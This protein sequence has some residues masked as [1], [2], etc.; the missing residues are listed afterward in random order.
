MNRPFCRLALFAT[1]CAGWAGKA[2]AQGTQPADQ[3]T[4]P[5]PPAQPGPAPGPQ[6]APYPYPYPYPY[7]APGPQ[8]GGYPQPQG[9]QLAPYPPTAYPLSGPTPYP[10]QYPVMPAAELA[11]A[12]APE[13]APMEIP[14]PEAGSRFAFGAVLGFT[15]ISEENSSLTVSN[16]LLQGRVVLWNHFLADVDWGFILARDSDAGFSARTGNP[17]I[18]AWYRRAFGG[19]QLQGG[20]GI[21]IP[22]ATTTLG[23]DGRLQRAL[24]NHSAALWGMADMWRWSPG[25]LAVPIVMEATR[26]LS[27]GQIYSAQLAVAPMT[28]VRA[29]EKG[30]D[31]VSQLAVTGRFMLVPTFWM[32]VRLQEVLLPSAS[33]DRWQMAAALRF[34]WT[35]RLGRFFLEGLMNL[36]EPVGVLGRGTGSWG[37]FLGK[38]LAR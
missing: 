31:V 35:P 2:E 34:E 12:P 4:P 1:V 22:L 17:W 36:D 21:S 3:A 20:V 5:A 27:M 29:G 11:P 37:I 26:R 25:R 15:H 24:Y 16:P 6:P 10:Y 19:W 18:K 9:P 13:P 28:G 38:E 33:V 8:H 7:A 23:P 14:D 32:A 30:T